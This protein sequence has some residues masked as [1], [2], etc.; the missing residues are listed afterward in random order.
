MYTGRDSS[1]DVYF[2][3]GDG[4]GFENGDYSYLKLTYSEE[5]HKLSV[6]KKGQYPVDELFNVEYVDRT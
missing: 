3:K 5:E 2:D 6:S 1:F 4:Y